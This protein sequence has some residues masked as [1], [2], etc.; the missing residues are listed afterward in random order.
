MLLRLGEETK[1]N[2]CYWTDR[3]PVARLALRKYQSSSSCNQLS[4]AAA[5]PAPLHAAAEPRA[6]AAAQVE[7]GGD[8]TAAEDVA[9]TE[10]IAAALVIVQVR[11]EMSM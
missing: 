4:G 9:P 8:L 5:G 2:A 11:T 7:P 3:H 6:V 10:D 1:I